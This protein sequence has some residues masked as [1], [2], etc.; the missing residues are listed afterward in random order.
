MVLNIRE[1]EVWYNKIQVIFGVNI[2][3]DRGEFVALLGNKGA[4]KTAIFRAIFGQVGKKRGKI[5]YWDED[6]T[7]AKPAELAK[8]GLSYV[9]QGKNI[10]LKLSVHDNI[11]LGAYAGVDGL[12]ESVALVYETFPELKPKK[13]KKA[14]ALDA[15]ECLMLALA[16]ALVI[17]PKLMLID[18]PSAGLA[19]KQQKDA[20]E[21]IKAIN[22]KGVAILLAEQNAAASL[23][24]AEKVYILENG[25]NILSGKPE[26]ARKQ[27]EK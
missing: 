10:F 25:R 23:R 1:L 5:Q 22:K 12:K 27:L 13:R 14:S 24:I 20:F 3:V 16:R 2:K 15:K 9:P 7:N 4:G 26:L 19:P 8:R 17:K 6:I 18:E 11:M 21:R